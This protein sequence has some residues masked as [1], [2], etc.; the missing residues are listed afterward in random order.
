MKHICRYTHNGKTQYAV[1]RTVIEA[2]AMAEKAI[3]FQDQLKE[4]QRGER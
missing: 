3:K 4:L 2:W 1:G